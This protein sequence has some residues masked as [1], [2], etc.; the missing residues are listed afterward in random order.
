MEMQVGNHLA[1]ISIISKDEHCVWLDIERQV[2]DADIATE[3][4]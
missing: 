4:G 1:D 2:F 3:G